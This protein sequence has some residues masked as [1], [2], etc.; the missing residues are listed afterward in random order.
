MLIL[1]QGENR[2]I[3]VAETY[4][5]RV[6][7]ARSVKSEAGQLAT[8]ILDLVKLIDDNTKDVV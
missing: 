7:G 6:L 5:K 2:R 4:A 1:T 3:R 8:M